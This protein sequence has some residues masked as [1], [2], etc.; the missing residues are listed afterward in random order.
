M[1]STTASVPARADDR[2]AVR[3]VLRQPRRPELGGP[4]RAHDPLLPAL[5][6]PTRRRRCPP[7]SSTRCPRSSSRSALF[8]LPLHVRRRLRAIARP[9]SSV[10]WRRPPSSSSACARPGRADHAPRAVRARR[11]D[12]ALHQARRRAAGARVSRQAAAA[13]SAGTSSPRSCSRSRWRC[14]HASGSTPPEQFILINT[15]V[16]LFAGLIPVPGGI[17]VTEAGLTWGSPGRHPHRHRFA[18]ALTPL[19]VFYLPPI[20]GLLLSVA[21]RT[22]LSLTVVPNHAVASTRHRTGRLRCGLSPRLPRSASDVGH[23][24]DSPGRVQHRWG[25]EGSEEQLRDGP[26]PRWPS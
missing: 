3:H 25:E 26:R 24:P 16:S 17:G 22:L 13:L 21:D 6:R 15:V 14:V 9:D 18:I 20:W 4:S 11:V 7:A 12:D 23:R 5:R 19:H 10:A 1:G 8:V 2:A